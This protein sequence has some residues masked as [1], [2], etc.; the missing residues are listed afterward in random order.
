VPGV[1]FAGKLGHGLHTVAEVAGKGDGVVLGDGHQAHRL[2]RSQV[3]RRYRTDQVA[4]HPQQFPV[5]EHM[6]FPEGSGDAAQAFSSDLVA[7]VLQ[8]THGASLPDRADET[9][10]LMKS[11][12]WYSPAF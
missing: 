7:H 2:V 12:S 3:V 4:L 1:A 6:A 9:V 8:S 11:F 10:G 5:I